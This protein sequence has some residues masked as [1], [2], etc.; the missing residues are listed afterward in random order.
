MFHSY[1][2]VNFYKVKTFST[3]QG[4]ENNETSKKK[5]EKHNELR[6]GGWVVAAFGQNLIKIYKTKS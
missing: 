3:G 6:N 2:I 5:K 4:E 1:L